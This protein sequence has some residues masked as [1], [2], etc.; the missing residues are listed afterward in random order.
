M[1]CP[2][3]RNRERQTGEHVIIIGLT[4]HAMAGE[5]EQFLASGFDGYLAK[6]V[7]GYDVQE[8]IGRCLAL[9]G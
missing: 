9:T 6:P 2:Q 1:C 8:E 3:I 7:D 4:G 5:K